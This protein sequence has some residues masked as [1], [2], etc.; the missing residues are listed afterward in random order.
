MTVAEKVKFIEECDRNPS[1]S[2]V[3]IAARLNVPVST[4]KTILSKK[5]DILQAAQNTGVASLKRKRDQEGRFLEL[6]KAI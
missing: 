4:L 3:S 6:D 2:K 5:D 1:E